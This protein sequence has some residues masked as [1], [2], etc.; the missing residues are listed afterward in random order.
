M[1]KTTKNIQTT[2][3]NN[4]QLKC[5]GKTTKKTYLVTWRIQ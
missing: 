5:N 1:R 2:G 3:E 4:E